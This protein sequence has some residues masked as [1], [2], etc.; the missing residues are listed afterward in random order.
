LR[1]ANAMKQSR[2]L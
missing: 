1:A 2:S